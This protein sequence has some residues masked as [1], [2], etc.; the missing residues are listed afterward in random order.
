MRER[1]KSSLP[2]MAALVL[3][4]C[5][6]QAY[7]E[8]AGLAPKDTGTSGTSTGEPGPPTTSSASGSGVQ[9]VTGAESTSPGSEGS[10]AGDETSAGGDLDLP[11]NAP[12]VIESFTADP[13][14]M[15]EAG[16]ASLALVASADVVLVRL[17]LNGEQILAGPPNKFPYDHE[18]L[19]AKHNFGHTFEVEVEDAE[20]LTDTA[21]T[22][23]SVQLPPSGAEKCLFKDA[24][25]QAS[26]ISGLVY[27]R[28]AIYAVGARDMGAG[29]K[30]TVWALD[31]DHCEDVLPGWPKTLEN[32]TAK[33]GL[34]A[35]AS[36]GA[37]ITVDESG[38][39]GVGGNL[40]VN[41]K[42]QPYVALLT[43]NGA[44]LWEKEGAVGEEIAGIAAFT[45]Q[46]SNRLVGVGWR[47]TSENPVRTD[48]MTWV[49]HALDGSVFVSSSSLKAPFTPDEQPDPFN[50]Q[51]EQ[52]RAVVVRG[53]IAFI[54][55]ERDFK[56]DNF[57]VYR[58][59]FLAR[60]HPLT[61]AE[62]L[63][64]SWGVHS[65]NDAARSITSCGESFIAGG[66]DRDKP[67]D[68]KPE[69]LIL[70][71]NTD[72]TPSNHRPEAL[73]WTQINGVAC[74]RE[75]KIL[76]AGTRFTGD[77][78]A[79]VFTVKGP[80]DQRVWYEQGGAGTDG[81]EAVSCDLRGFCAVAGLRSADGKAYAVVRVHHP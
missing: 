47:R 57:N 39:L 61:S 13:P 1:T 68:A 50:F 54:V 20:G 80:I 72:G 64:T 23:L 32:W 5:I 30:L 51:S 4:G 18:V 26:V 27:A 17:R 73:P 29:L 44:R 48:A 56:D 77:G 43:P 38:N 53:G 42:P 9:T 79:Q 3:A 71:F 66:W 10:S 33:P 69:P 62:P 35:L 37:A 36:A 24:G 76:S 34:A 67:A 15:S 16:T 70:W 45:G 74:D 8:G 75:H 78:D 65:L 25:A 14:H 40:L 22:E 52:A 59:A 63:W 12:P 46:F 6:E 49:F 28:K 2:L 41:G 58:R 7:Q 31:P 21:T 81:A 11:A 60:L 55:G 19:S